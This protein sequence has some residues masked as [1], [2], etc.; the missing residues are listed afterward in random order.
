ML[1]KKSNIRKSYAVEIDLSLAEKQ[2]PTDTTLSLLK[3]NFICM[4]HLLNRC[5]TLQEV[6][7]NLYDRLLHFKSLSDVRSTLE[8]KLSRPLLLPWHS[9]PDLPDTTLLRTLAGHKNDVTDCAISPIGDFIVSASWDHTLKVWDTYTGIERFSFK[10]HKG[11]VE[12]CA[13]SPDG[14]F[15][16]LCFSRSYS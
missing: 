2:A 10:E 4:G 5:N 3:R 9:L 13:I 11:Q 15:H 12:A 16:H 14:K 8:Q 1:Q 6:R 7:C